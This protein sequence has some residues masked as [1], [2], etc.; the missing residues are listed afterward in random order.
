MFELQL[1]QVFFILSCSSYL[2]TIISHYFLKVKYFL[3][4][5]LNYFSLNSSKSNFSIL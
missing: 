3:K 4:I 1:V 5:F 2:D